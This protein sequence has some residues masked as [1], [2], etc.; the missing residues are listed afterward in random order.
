[1]PERRVQMRG[2]IH[3]S[4]VPGSVGTDGLTFS[5]FA[6]ALE[7]LVDGLEADYARGFVSRK[8][9]KELKAIVRQAQQLCGRP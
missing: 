4:T 8:T 6:V 5:L 3:N 9:A 7:Q 1:M 2:R